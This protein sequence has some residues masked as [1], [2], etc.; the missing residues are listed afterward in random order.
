MHIQGDSSSLV[1]E[2]QNQ[3]ILC[4]AQPMGDLHQRQK[5]A[6]SPSQIQ[7]NTEHALPE[8]LLGIQSLSIQRQPLTSNS[9]QLV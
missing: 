4:D 8:D 5:L 6:P 7:T 1:L 2:N 3:S 9:S